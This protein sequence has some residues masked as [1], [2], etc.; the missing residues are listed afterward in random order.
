[1]NLDEKL[2]NMIGYIGTKVPGLG[3][4]VFK[5]GK[6]VYSKFLGR[7]H[8]NIDK[9]VTRH[10]RFR[11]ASLSKMF[12]MFTIMQLV[13]EDKIY[14]DKDASEYLG[15]KLRNPNFADTPITVRTLA[16]HTSSIRDDKVYSLPPEFS[17]KEFFDEDGKFYNNGVHFAPKEE[18][19][20]KY[21]TYCNLNYGLLG[22]IIERV[23]G[24]RFDLYQ[25]KHI[26]QQLETKADYVVG[27]LG[28][29]EFNNL[30]TL[31][32]KNK[33][34]EWNEHFSWIAQIDDYTVQP[35]KDMVLVQNPY[36]RDMDTMYSLNNYNIGTN[37]T[38]FSP[39]GGLRI[40]F[41][42]LSHCL[43]MLINGGTYKGREIIRAD[44][45]SE[46]MKPQWTYN[47][48]KPNG[49]TSSVMFNYGF[50]IYKIEGNGNARLCKNYAIDLIGHSG[51][52]YGLISGLYF[53][54]GT[55]NGV[56]FMINGEAVEPDKNEKS[57]GRFSNCYIW[58]EELMNP[59]CE[60]FFIN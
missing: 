13:G 47:K 6:E 23:T 48:K 37:A 38:I 53:I 3:V 30:G 24:E 10:T 31:Y 12:T 34:G 36:A 21:F 33:N 51:E 42:E 54:P 45:L 60:Y 17:V 9:P 50:G 20:G 8:I 44:L 57:L 5:N 4:I 43:E 18:E 49:D 59:I 32:Q 16:S 41:E 28:K 19:I 7:R 39:T 2:E 58:E 15:F 46:M 35:E 26:L 55:K 11:A 22:T 1:M 14:L 27:N 40:S 29:D 56:I 52:A 25:K